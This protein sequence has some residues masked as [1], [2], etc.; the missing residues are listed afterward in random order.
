[1]KNLVFVGGG[2]FFLEL[3]DYIKRDLSVTEKF[4]IKGIIDDVKTQSELPLRLLSNVED[5]D[6]E[7]DDVFLIT[8]GSPLNRDKLYK[9]LKMKGACF[10]SY[11]HPSAYIAETASIEEGCIVAPYSIVNAKAVI[12]ANVAVN[13]HCSVGHESN[14][15]QS[16]VLSPYSAVNGN[17]IVGDQC[18]LGTRA[19]V[20]P[21]MVLGD[22]SIVDSHSYVKSN[23]DSKSIVSLRGEYVVVK[24][25]LMR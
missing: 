23:V 6:P 24:N 21:K 4:S 25:R 15:G 11:I 18:F 17:A 2:G 3:F 16:S 22:K 10:I 20:F 14:L 9:S 1:M 12:K 13:V 7:I 8:L 19:T 5:Y